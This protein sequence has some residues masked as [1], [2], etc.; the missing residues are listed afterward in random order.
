[1][2]KPPPGGFIYIL[3][4][5]R[6]TDFRKTIKG[7]DF[8]FHGV[9]EGKDQVFRVSADTHNFKMT[10]DEDGNWGIW[11]QVPSWIKALEE[12]LE[13]AIEEQEKR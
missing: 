1:M 12:D 5:N 4:N 3:Q 6:M 7:I 11:Q 8:N 2:L 13:K 9:M 10:T